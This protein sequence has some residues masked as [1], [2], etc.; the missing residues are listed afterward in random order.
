MAF[1]LPRAHSDPLP[2]CPHCR[3]VDDTVTSLRWTTGK[4]GVYCTDCDF[5]H[6]KSKRIA[7]AKVEKDDEQYISMHI[8]DWSFLVNGTYS[9]GLWTGRWQASAVVGILSA[10]ASSA[11]TIIALRWVFHNITGL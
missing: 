1:K 10:L 8:D 6:F 7:G 9:D 11:V 2:R 3:S 4:E 5:M